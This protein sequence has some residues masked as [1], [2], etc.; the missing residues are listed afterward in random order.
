MISKKALGLIETVGLAAA[1][2]AADQA[3][4]SANVELVGYELSKGG[5]MVTVKI[6]GDVGAVKAAVQA[7]VHSAGVISKVVSAKVIARPSPQIEPMVLSPETVGSGVA[8][9][10]E[11]PIAPKQEEEE[12]EKQAL[13]SEEAQTEETKIE[14]EAESEAE[15]E[16]QESSEKEVTPEEKASAE[17]NITQIMQVKEKKNPTCNLCKDVKCTRKKGEPK[18]HCIHEKSKNKFTA[19]ENKR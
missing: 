17:S 12:P 11:V 2:E 4:K 7:A 3:V 5:G 6:V 10:K 14:E 18:S 9:V 1:T 19:K 16:P 13:T 15:E 8:K